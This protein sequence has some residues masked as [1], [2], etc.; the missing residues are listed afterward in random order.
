MDNEIKRIIF[1]VE[2]ISP[3]ITQAQIS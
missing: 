1:Q 2:S 3:L